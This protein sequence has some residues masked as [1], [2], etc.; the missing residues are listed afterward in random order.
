MES[1]CVDRF[2]AMVTT[3]GALGDTKCAL[4]TGDA[5][6]ETGTRIVDNGGGAGAT[7]PARVVTISDIVP[8]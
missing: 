1:L 4:V 8:I 5:G 3:G 6:D 7:N 2:V